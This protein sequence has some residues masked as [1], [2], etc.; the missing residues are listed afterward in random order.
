MHGRSFSCCWRG[1]DLRFPPDYRHRLMQL[2]LV[3]SEQHPEAE[4][5]RR[6][7]WWWIGTGKGIG[8]GTDGGRTEESR[9]CR[10]RDRTAPAR[11]EI[12]S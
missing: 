10:C 11:D 9:A 6:R 1:S 5:R 7:R 8:M 3:R 2:Q 4:E 12:I